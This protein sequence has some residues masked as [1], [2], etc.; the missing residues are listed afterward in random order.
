MDLTDLYR[1]F[2]SSVSEYTFF[3]NIHVTFSRTDHM[4]GHRTVL[5]KFRNTR[6]L[7]SIQ[8]GQNNVQLET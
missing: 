8:S 6:V 2:L 5:D 4:L 7:P 1:V 3:S